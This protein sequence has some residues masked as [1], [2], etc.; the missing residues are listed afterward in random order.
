MRSL[1]GLQRRYHVLGSGFNDLLLVHLVVLVLSTSMRQGG[2]WVGRSPGLQKPLLS[3]HLT[4]GD[5]V[6]F[7]LRMRGCP[8]RRTAEMPDLV[9]VT[10]PGRT[11]VRGAPA[12]RSREWRWPGRWCW[13]R[14]CC[15][16]TAVLGAGRRSCGSGCG[17]WSGV[18]PPTRFYPDP[19]T[20]AAARFFGLTN[21]IPGTATGSSF[22]CSLG[23][24]VLAAPA[25]DALGA[26]IARPETLR[27]LGAADAP[28]TVATT[29]RE[30]RFCGTTVR[31]SRWSRYHRAHHGGRPGRSG[32]AGRPGPPAAPPAACRML[33]G[34]MPSPSP[35]P[36]RP[37]RTRTP[38]R[39][40]TV[41]IPLDDILLTDVS[42]GDP[43]DLGLLSGVWVLTLIRH[44]Y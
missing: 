4:V 19:P 22:A 30:I 42:S 11:P 33:P 32:R 17:S 13:T 23:E 6:A 3:G 20:L 5:N 44:R 25:A 37:T 38:V 34:D 1:H 27:L 16:S 2:R 29:V 24:L 12:G 31:W 7:G 9:G 28:I 10:R 26:L 39:E 21:E 8:E 36:T 18:G 40:L 43:V 35:S 15:S 14:G 41:D